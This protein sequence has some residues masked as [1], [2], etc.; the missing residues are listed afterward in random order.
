MVKCPRCHAEN[1]DDSKFCS[2][3]GAP[4]IPGVGPPVDKE[5][6]F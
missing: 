5:M 4:L 2:N 3:C 1:R 6:E